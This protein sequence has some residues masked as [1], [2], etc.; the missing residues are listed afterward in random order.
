ME[1][2]SNFEIA[3]AM[4]AQPHVGLG[5]A[6]DQPD[7]E[8]IRR[9]R[10][11]L[12]ALMR[13]QHDEI[14]K[15]IN[16]MV[17]AANPDLKH[18]SSLDKVLYLS[19]DANIAAAR[20]LIGYEIELDESVVPQPAIA[21]ARR[22]AQHDVPVG[23]LIR[24]Y[25]LGQGDMNDW[26]I[27]Q[28]REM[29][30]ELGADGVLEAGANVSKVLFGYI[31]VVSERIIAEYVNARRLLDRGDA[32]RLAR[33]VRE[34]LDGGPIKVG[35]AEPILGYRLR[36]THTGIVA[37][38]DEGVGESD[39]LAAIETATKALQRSL[40]SRLKV[41]AVPRDDHSAYLWIPADFAQLDDA[42]C[43]AIA[44]AGVRIAVGSLA[45]GPEGFRRSMQQAQQV[46]HIA[47]LDG[48]P[49]HEVTRYGEVA[50]IVGLA[51][52]PELSRAWIT[53]TLGGLATDDEA[54]Q[55]F[56][57]TASTFLAEGGSFQRAAGLLN[58][59][60]NTVAYRIQ[61]V[62]QILGRKVSEDRLN[63]ELALLAVRHLGLD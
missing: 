30:D 33:T 55:V 25:R 34:I 20:R 10:Y 44:G 58:V 39:A 45:K 8:D 24:A 15:T 59:H 17:V 12:A 36:Q 47:S 26:I 9:A 16:D 53:E 62:E 29:S 51:A 7:S 35:D 57:E 19:T 5:A 37:W 60:K 1:K 32:A 43:R 42:E 27:A 61:R 11:I 22:L 14:T 31:D 63:L 46:H 49:E 50:P 40:G 23:G 38:V 2:P 56:R 41:L 18:D 52:N 54:T 48:A 4:S 3:H 21:Y 28:L 13:D 6:Q